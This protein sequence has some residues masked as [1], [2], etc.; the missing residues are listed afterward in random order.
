MLWIKALF[1][2]PVEFPKCRHIFRYHTRVSS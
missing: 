1:W 2:N